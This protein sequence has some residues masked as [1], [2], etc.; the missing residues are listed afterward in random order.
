MRFEFV[1]LRFEFVVERAQERVLKFDAT[2]PEREAISV[3]LLAILISLTCIRP[4]RLMTVVSVFARRP[5]RLMISVRIFA[6][7]PESDDCMVLSRLIVDV[8]PLTELVRSDQLSVRELALMI[9]PVPTDPQILEVN[10]F[11]EEESTLLVTILFVI[12]V[13]KDPVPAVTPDA[14]MY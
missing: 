11:P 3:V 7:V 9:T 2:V 13:S 14:V 5:E 10:I 1:V 4:E 6:T 12:S 8:T